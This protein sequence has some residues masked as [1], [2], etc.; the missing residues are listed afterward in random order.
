[1]ARR[2]LSTTTKRA[3]TAR[4]QSE[5]R[6]TKAT[7]AK[8]LEA[9]SVRL[10]ELTSTLWWD[11]NDESGAIAKYTEAVE[12]LEDLAPR[13]AV[14]RLL[15]T[16]MMAIHN[17]TIECFRRAMIG[18]QALVA[19]DSNLKHAQK[20]TATFAAHLERLNKYRGKG[21]QKVTVEHVNVAAGGQAIV[22][23]LD[24]R[25]AAVTSRPRRKLAAPQVEP[26][27]AVAPPP[28]NAREELTIRI[29]KRR[30]P[31]HG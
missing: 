28:V 6:I 7:G 1:M 23:N 4:R 12:T 21:Q 25:A 11:G 17:A 10:N 14:E 19:R 22:G 31:D 24:H 2:A 20:L 5:A 16:Q 15:V 3:E 29:R 9:A 27:I 26:H 30:K 18:G 8:S 13:D